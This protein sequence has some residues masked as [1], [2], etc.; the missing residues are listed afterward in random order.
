MKVSMYE[1]LHWDII[2]D[3]EGGY[4]AP[5]DSVIL[6]PGIP[7][8]QQAQY[9]GYNLPP[10]ARVIPG[11]AWL[12]YLARM[13]SQH[14]KV[15]EEIYTADIPVEKTLEQKEHV[16]RLQNQAFVQEREIRR[17]EQKIKRD[18]RKQEMDKLERRTVEMDIET[19]SREWLIGRNE[20]FDFE[21]E[22][23][24][25]RIELQF[26]SASYIIRNAVVRFFEQNDGER[27]MQ[28]AILSSMG[29]KVL[30]I[31]PSRMTDVEWAMCN[32][33]RSIYPE[34]SHEFTT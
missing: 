27:Q 32:L 13:Q 11:A 9:V 4:E 22:L 21:T 30:D 31:A 7:Q 12:D 8:A 19:T 23:L 18:K 15:E 14:A 3:P 17:I 5:Y 28:K 16:E 6:P 24:G 34:R 33:M 20:D 10:S 29:Y 2:L 1:E 25:G 26:I